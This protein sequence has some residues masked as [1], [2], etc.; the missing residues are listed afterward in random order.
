MHRLFALAVLATLGGLTPPAR[1]AAA[2]P[3]VNVVVVLADDLGWTDLACY[4]SDLHETPHLDR[5]A[6][7]GMRFTQNYS[8]C[9]V[10]SPTRAA[11]LT[12][13]YPAR[14]H[15]T[16][17]IPG[18]PPENPKLT[19]PDFTKQLPLEEK[20]IADVLHAAGYAPA[21]VGKWPRGG[22]PFYPEHHGFDLNVAGTEA[23]QPNS[24]VDGKPRQ[25][26]FAPYAIDTIKQGPPGEYITD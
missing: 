26:Y 9:T 19:V 23:P 25:G 3:P 1:L 11:L 12:G 22:P 7:D 4:G 24:L 13:K 8:A 6:A 18:L 20:T 2:D 5:L 10:C 15:I 16:D 14:L 21:S 17:W